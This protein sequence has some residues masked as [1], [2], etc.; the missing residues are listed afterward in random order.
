MYLYRRPSLVFSVAERLN[1]AVCAT[2]LPRDAEIASVMNHL[3]REQ[4]PA[5]L[6]DDLHQ[7]LLDLLRL[8][9]LCELPAA[10]D[11]MHVRIYDYSHSFVEPTAQNNIRCLPRHSGQRKELIDIVGNLPTE[12]A[13]DLLRGSNDRL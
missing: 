2:R 9:V 13:D 4:Y 6:R 7:I 5:I 10:R 8:V 11:T 3:V 1:R 12:I